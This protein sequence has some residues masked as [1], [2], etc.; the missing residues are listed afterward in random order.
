MKKEFD[1]SKAK[2]ISID[3]GGKNYIGRYYLKSKRILTVISNY[4]SETTQLGGL[5]EE[6]LARMLLSE[7]VNKYLKK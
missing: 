4:G 1:Y 6:S 2:N 5:T 3:V 7:L